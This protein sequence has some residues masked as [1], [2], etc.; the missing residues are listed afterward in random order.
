MSGVDIEAAKEIR[1]TIK[2]GEVEKAITLIGSNGDLLHLMTPLGTWLHVAASFGQ[3]EVM[4]RLIAMGLDLN[5]KGGIF[6]AAPLNIAASKGHIDIVKYL[7]ASGA[8]LDVSEP[9]RNPLFAAI[10]GGHLEIVKLLL[11]Q[12]IDATVKYT[13][14]SMEGMDAHAFALERGQTEIA[15][16][17]EQNGT[18]MK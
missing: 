1:M 14:P 13:G 15:P 12:G 17:M 8:E 18:G 4:K 7:L 11:E 2:E 5:R 10:Y 9:E 3:L 6:E 16:F